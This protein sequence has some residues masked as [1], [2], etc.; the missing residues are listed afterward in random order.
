MQ[1]KVLHMTFDIDSDVLSWQ[2]SVLTGVVYKN[3]YLNELCGI[4]KRMELCLLG[5]PNEAE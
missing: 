5:L 3:S 4:E 2:I 1:S